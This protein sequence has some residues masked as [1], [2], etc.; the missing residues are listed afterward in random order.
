MSAT[1]EFPLGKNT[2]GCNSFNGYIARSFGAKTGSYLARGFLD[3]S[4][5]EKEVPGSWVWA[6]VSEAIEAG[7]HPKPGD[8][9]S[10]PLGDQMFGHVGVVVDFD[11]ASQ[12]WTHVDGGQGGKSV[13]KDFIKWAKAK[14]FNRD[15]I[16]GWVDM[17]VYLMPDGPEYS[18]GPDGF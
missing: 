9:Y 18:I 10:M 13:G 11:G 5:A 7:L 8:F 12:T 3:I 14:K 1:V 2:T 15:K 4:K 17:A 6:N 16:N